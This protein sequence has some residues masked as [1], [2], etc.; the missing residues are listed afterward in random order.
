M[1]LNRMQKEV[2]LSEKRVVVITAQ[3]GSGTTTALLLKLADEASKN[4]N[5]LVVY[6]RRT[7]P[8]VLSVIQSF[9]CSMPKS[10]YSEK[11]RILSFQYK[12]KKVKIKMLDFDSVMKEPYVPVVAVDIGSNFDNLP[13]L[14]DNSGKIFISDFAKDV[15]KKNSWAY[16]SNLIS[17]IA[18]IPTWKNNVDHIVGYNLDN[19]GLSDS[20][21]HHVNFLD[22]DS[23]DRL[24]SVEI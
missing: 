22:K 19:P 5:N 15:G 17:D 13:M 20:Y 12:G 10:R 14:I 2:L 6:V 9:L 11:S 23:Y 18:G 3:A 1:I 16:G 8:Q 7:Y 24:M 4:T 21:H